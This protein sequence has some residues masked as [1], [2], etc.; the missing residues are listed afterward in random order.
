[1]GLAL[2]GVGTPCAFLKKTYSVTF[3]R[4]RSSLPEDE[5]VSLLD[6]DECSV[7]GDGESSRELQRFVSRMVLFIERKCIGMKRMELAGKNS[8]ANASSIR[9]VTR[10]R[11]R[12][13]FVVCVR[14]DGYEVSLERGKIYERLPEDKGETHGYIRVLDESG[15]DYLFPADSFMPIALPR[16]VERALRL[17][18]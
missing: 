13:R 16:K 3:G 14:N 8:K 12:R 17:A 2:R 10:P 6:Y 11:S 18:S 4:S 5:F 9:R 1:M 7:E 15:E